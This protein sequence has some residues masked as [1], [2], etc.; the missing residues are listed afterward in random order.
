MTTE[1]LQKAFDSTRNILQN[2]T[3][4][5]MD[6]DTPCA[7]WK[8]KDVVNHIVG[9]AQWFG[10]TMNAGEAKDTGESFPDF[11]TMDYMDIFNDGVKKS[12]DA[13]GK[14]G[15]Q[16]KMVKLPFGEFPGGA[17]M[18]L[19]TTDTF[20]HGWDLAKSTG[21]DANLDPELAKQLLDGAKA[22]IPDEFRGPDG[23]A[24]FGPEV[25]AP[26]DAPMADQLAAFLGR[27]L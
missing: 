2:V 21:Q 1:A 18:G 17:F 12:V 24:P 27:N 26:A 25:D 10:D 22:T 23:K 19:A 3:P 13:F 20:V 7:S 9:G 5:Q 14:E 4:D 6:N 15:A 16:Q 11:S 8:V